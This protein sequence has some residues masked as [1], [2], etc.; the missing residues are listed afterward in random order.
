MGGP[1]W[2]YLLGGETR[3]N[4]GKSPGSIPWYFLLSLAPC[5]GAAGEGLMHSKRKG[6]LVP[7]GSAPQQRWLGREGVDQSET[8]LRSLAMASLA[9]LEWRWGWSCA[10]ATARW[11]GARQAGLSSQG[12]E[13]ARQAVG[14]E[15]PPLRLLQTTAPFLSPT[16]LASPLLSASRGPGQPAAIGG[17][18]RPP[19]YHS[20]PRERFHS[21]IL[22]GTPD[23]VEGW[24]NNFCLWFNRLNS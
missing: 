6:Q 16:H 9:A 14:Q 7:P 20:I 22:E 23:W 5:V 18:P 10:G 8:A 4:S 1:R 21:R 24:E 2:H 19:A 11:Q 13:A 3:L 12:K 15:Q 17:F